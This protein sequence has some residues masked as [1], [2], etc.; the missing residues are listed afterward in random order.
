MCYYHRA[1]GS[2]AKKCRAPCSWSEN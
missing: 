2:R 1:W